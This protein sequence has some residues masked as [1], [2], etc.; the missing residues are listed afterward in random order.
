MPSRPVSPRGL[1]AL[2]QHQIQ[3][4]QLEQGRRAPGP[5]PCVAVSHM[6]GSGA[7]DVA[8]L[9]AQRLGF[10]F[11]DREIVD[12]IAREEGTQRWLVED[13]DEHVRT[14][15]DRFVLDAFR[16]RRFSESDYLHG[17]LRVVGTLSERGGAV[18][19]GRGSTFALPLDRTLRVFVVAPRKVRVERWAK[20]HGYGPEEE[21]E[22]LARRDAER[23]EFLARNFDVDPDDPT[24]FDLVVNTATL[25]VE[26]A[27]ELVVAA[28]RQ[29]FPGAA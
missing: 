10:G 19:L 16:G 15:I 3:R 29:R 23:R 7:R 25:T 1:D 4:W 13:V 11:F 14:A 5:A 6:H 26:G 24:H 22:R 20:E 21:A 17:L 2:V 28:L 12:Q 8:R 27:A 18:I 9:V